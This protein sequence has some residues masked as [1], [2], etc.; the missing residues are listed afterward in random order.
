MRR[1]TVS[2]VLLLAVLGMASA[3]EV[4]FKTGVNVTVS[5]SAV[6]DDE[7]KEAGLGWRNMEE[8]PLLNGLMSTSTGAFVN[9]SGGEFDIEVD[10]AFYTDAG[11]V[12]VNSRFSEEFTLPTILTWDAQASDNIIASFPYALIEID[13]D[14]NDVMVHKLTDFLW[15]MTDD[16][17]TAATVQGQIIV[18]MFKG[19]IDINGTTC[20]IMFSVQT[21]AVAGVSTYLEQELLPK[22]WA[23]V[24]ELQNYTLQAA[25]NSLRMQYAV[26]TGTAQLDDEGKITCQ[27]TEGDVEKLQAYVDIKETAT[28]DGNG[29]SV[30]L[31][32]FA[33]ATLD[34]ASLFPTVKAQMDAKYAADF[35]VYLCNATFESGSNGFTHGGRSGTG[36]RLAAATPAGPSGGS[37]ANSLHYGTA[38]ILAMFALVGLLF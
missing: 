9:Q 24:L 6:S 4:S 14:K 34:F 13:G 20:N 37:D 32:S 8:V 21:S 36:K 23:F 25:E 1:A 17:T 15:E 2:V 33:E 5:G 12:T 10:A 11:P 7:L 19:S 31:E 22:T 30:E 29:I 35:K 28:F 18:K 38:M 3:V 26:A 16:L 27:G